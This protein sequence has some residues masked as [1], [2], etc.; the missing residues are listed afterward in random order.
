MALALAISIGADLFDYTMVPLFGMPIIGDIF[1]LIVTWMLYSIT[2]SKV[3]L[4]MNLAEFI[5]FFGD[6]L[7]VYTVSTIIWILRQFGYDG[8]II[9]KG[10][11]FL[12]STDNLKQ[13]IS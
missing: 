8:L 6:F 9:A 11:R 13:K 5:P 4:V 2:R 1:D 12:S 3:S 7:P 10:L